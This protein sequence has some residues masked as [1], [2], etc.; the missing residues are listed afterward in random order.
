MWLQEKFAEAQRTGFPFVLPSRNALPSD[1]VHSGPITEDQVYIIA[2][3]YCWAGPG[4][5]D[6][7]NRLLSDVRELLMSMRS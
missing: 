3:S 5:P 1:A 6:P 2:L 7:E 4:R